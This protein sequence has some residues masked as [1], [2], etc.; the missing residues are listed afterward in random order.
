MTVRRAAAALRRS[1]E[2]LTDVEGQL[3]GL[4]SALRAKG[5][6]ANDSADRLHDATAEVEDLLGSLADLR[7]LF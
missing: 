1:R 6:V 3:E 4:L 5:G 7:T 2:L